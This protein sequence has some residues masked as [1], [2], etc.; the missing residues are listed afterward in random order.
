MFIIN[1]KSCR[2]RVSLISNVTLKY[3]CLSITVAV[4]TSVLSAPCLS[5]LLQWFFRRPLRLPAW[6]D[7]MKARSVR[8]AALFVKK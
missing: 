4:L 5:S 3:C 2:R 8:M 7:D 1:L 6:A